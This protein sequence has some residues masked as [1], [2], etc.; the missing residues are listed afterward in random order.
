MTGVKQSKGY[1]NHFVVWPNCC[2]SLDIIRKST[3]SFQS[4]H[5]YF[6]GNW[7]GG[8]VY[9]VKGSIFLGDY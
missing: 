1:G 7:Q 3:V 6:N 9:E 5:S 8:E 2:L 4:N